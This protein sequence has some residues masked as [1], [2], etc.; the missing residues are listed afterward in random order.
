MF[1]VHAHRLLADKPDW[2]PLVRCKRSEEGDD[3][4][5]VGYNS[6]VGFMQV[7]CRAAVIT[8]KITRNIEKSR[9]EFGLGLMMFATARHTIVEVE[10][11]I[12]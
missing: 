1:S 4:V 8:R 3:L 11:S 7:S 6:E 12:E 2:S 9:R 5:M 10:S